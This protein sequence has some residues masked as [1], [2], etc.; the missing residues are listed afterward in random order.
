MQK[1][2][3]SLLK[4]QFLVALTVAGCVW[5]LF[6]IRG[7]IVA[8]FLAYIIMAALYPLVELLIRKGISKSLAVFF[9]FIV[10]LLLLV[11]L[12]FPLIPFFVSQIQSFIVKFPVYLKQ[13]S[14]LFG[15]DIDAKQIQSLV[16]DRVTTI[17][18]NALAVSAKI[19]GG[20]FTG[21][22]IIV[23]SFYLLLAHD[24]MNKGFLRMFPKQNREEIK[25]IILRVEDK[26]GSWLRGQLVLSV[27]VGVLTWIALTVAG[28]D[29]ALPLAIMAGLL[30]ILPTIGPIIAAVPAI[31]VALSASPTLAFITLGIY[32]VIQLLENHILVPRIMAKAVGLNPLVVLLGIIIGAKLLGVAGAL[33][34]VPFISLITVII[35]SIQVTQ[36][37]EA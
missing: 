24:D 21:I 27:S 17:G 22:T 13:L 31:I 16:N 3:P 25:D 29:Y 14:P 34:S 37:K 8:I 12:I 1:I 10:M 19:F 20:F 35:N 6:Q 2:F 15:L 11:V 36:Q 26:L 30:E 32:V 5:L 18:E 9:V 33:L 28:V 4:N 23:V 7:I